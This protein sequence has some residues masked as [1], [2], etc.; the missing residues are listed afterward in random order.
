M[1]L[2]VAI[3]TTRSHDTDRQKIKAISGFLTSKYNECSELPNVFSANLICTKEG[4]IQ[5]KVLMGA[6][7]YCIKKTRCRQKAILELSDGY[8]NLAG[9][10]S[11]TKMGFNKDIELNKLACFIDLLNL[12]MSVDLNTMTEDQIIGCVNGTFTPN[13]QDD[14]GLFS[15]G[16]P[17]NSKQVELQRILALRSHE[18][19]LL[20]LAEDLSRQYDVSSFEEFIHLSTVYGTSNFS[21]AKQKCK[22]V[23]DRLLKKYREPK[24]SKCT[25]F[26]GKRTKR[27]FK[28]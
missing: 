14:T 18:F 9:F 20:Q 11:Y 26:G 27:K 4:Q 5:A 12:P 28:F 17:C 19:Y 21:I 10:F 1:D 15:T 7:L 3:D 8:K 22:A 16:R 6:F 23:M 2:I 25:I 24:E 13:I